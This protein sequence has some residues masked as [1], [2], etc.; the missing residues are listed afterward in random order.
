MQQ[1]DWQQTLYFTNYGNLTD[2]GNVQI[3]RQST[4]GLD[5]S[6]SGY[7]KSFNYPL[8]A[9]SA[10]STFLDNYTI[11]ATVERGKNTQ[12]IGQ[13]VFPTGLESFSP[14]QGLPFA[15][16]N[17]QGA[18]LSTAQNGSATYIANQTSSTSFSFG[19]TTQDMAF[20]G[21][22]IGSL[23]DAKGIPSIAGTIELF[24][25]YVEA[26]NGTVVEDDET[27][28]DNEIHH[29]HLGLD[30]T[31]NFAGSGVKEMLGRGPQGA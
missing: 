16:S 14:A 2:A 9:Y 31:R 25:R 11:Q 13:S 30:S 15:Y 6:S 21:L 22:E 5:I 7:S 3:N 4:T 26:V 20:S 29:T 27:L 28:V 8:L 23:V 12:I 1:A 24:H 18:A 17:F 10:Y 19:T